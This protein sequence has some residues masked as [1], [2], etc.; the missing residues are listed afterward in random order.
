MLCIDVP[1]VD[2]GADIRKNKD[3]PIAGQGIPTVR[4]GIPARVTV[5][6][7]PVIVMMASGAKV[8]NPVMMANIMMAA[9][10]VKVSNPVK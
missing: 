1:V 6:T 2:P 5:M 3:R 9:N 8:D 7:A 10:L 4:H